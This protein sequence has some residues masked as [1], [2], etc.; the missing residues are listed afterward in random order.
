MV[1]FHGSWNR[2][3]AAGYNVVFVAFGP[4]NKPMDALP[5]DIL[6]GFLNANGEAMGRPADAQP[7]KD[8]ALLVADDVGNVIWRVVRR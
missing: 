6:T 5:I 7:A 1:R 8:G 3:P 4:D 2:V